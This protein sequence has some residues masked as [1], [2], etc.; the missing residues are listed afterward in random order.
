MSGLIHHGHPLVG[1]LQGS[2]MGLLSFCKTQLRE[3]GP[4]IYV[5][6]SGLQD[7]AIPAT[8]VTGS[9]ASLAQVAKN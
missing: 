1:V 3:M 9:E 8:G 5:E 2:K 6:A 7:L 4:K